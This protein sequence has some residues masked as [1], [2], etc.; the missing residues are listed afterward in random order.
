VHAWAQA[1][2]LGIDTILLPR[3]APAFSAYGL[4]VADLLVDL[5]RAYV[6]P[7]SA[8]DIAAA[9]DL[10]VDMHGEARKELEPAGI[11]P[12]T[13][14]LRFY[15]TLCYPGQNFDMSIPWP[16]DP[17]SGVPNQAD[18]LDLAEAFHT[19]HEADRGFSFRRQEPLLR[20]LRVVATAPTPTPAVPTPTGTSTPDE[21]RTGTRPAYFGHGW[22]DTPVYDGPALEVD[23]VVHGPALVQEPF[24]VCVVGPGQKLTLD[25]TGTYVLTRA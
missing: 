2:L 7:L 1:D 4:L 24:T 23:S 15:G 22:V 13:V 20:S 16:V 3:T 5:V 12:A 11:D 9:Q 25:A 6:S 18:L 17:T 8:V 21:A 10:L 14:D 19:A